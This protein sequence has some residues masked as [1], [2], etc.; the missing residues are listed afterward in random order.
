M[1][2]CLTGGEPDKFPP[3][4]GKQRL[5]EIKA[6]PRNLRATGKDLIMLM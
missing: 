4:L 1:S 6:L 3:G 5:A 2:R